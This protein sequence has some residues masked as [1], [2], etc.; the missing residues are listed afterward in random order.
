[1][2]QQF[3]RLAERLLAGCTFEQT[4][5]TVNLLVVQQVGWLKEPLI[6]EVTLERAIGCIFVS[7]TMAYQRVLLFEA[8]LALLTLERSLLRVGSLV[9]PEVGWALKALSAGTAAERPF[10]FGLALMMQELGRL[11]KVHLA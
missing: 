4:F 5:H 6:T 10:A 8:H 9:L 2:P 11:F 3:P 7:A 1:M